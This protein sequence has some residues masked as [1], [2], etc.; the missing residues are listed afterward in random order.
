MAIPIGR[1]VRIQAYLKRSAPVAGKVEMPRTPGV[2]EGDGL[3]EGDGDGDGVGVGAGVGEGDGLGEGEG[4][5]LGL[6]LGFGLPPQL[7]LLS[8][9]KSLSLPQPL[10]S[11]K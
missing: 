1:R 6:A 11:S 4:F 3:G 5:G 7:P 8:S 10:L 9:A 2:G